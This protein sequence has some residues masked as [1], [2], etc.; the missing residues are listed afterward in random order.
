MSF[1][2]SGGWVPIW[3]LAAIAALY[4]NSKRL[5]DAD[6]LFTQC[7]QPANAASERWPSG[8][9]VKIQP[10]FHHPQPAGQIPRR[11]LPSMVNK[12]QSGGLYII[13]Y[14]VSSST[15]TSKVIWWPIIFDHAFVESSNFELIIGGRLG[16]RQSV[17]GGSTA[18]WSIHRRN[19]SQQPVYSQHHN[20]TTYVPI[21][22]TRRY[23][24]VSFT[25]YTDG[26][27]VSSCAKPKQPWY[28]HTGLFLSLITVTIP[29]STGYAPFLL[30]CFGT[31]SHPSFRGLQH[32]VD[33]R[34]GG[35]SPAGLLTQWDCPHDELSGVTSAFN[36][37][38]QEFAYMVFSHEGVTWFAG[39][40]AKLI[41]AAQ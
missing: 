41:N 31:G 12:F 4:R 27:L 13:F 18:P 15:A 21:N 17:R 9:R 40:G 32:L 25:Y 33:W 5:C 1:G 3:Q 26:S 29:A 2:Y 36:C 28:P 39:P 8:L 23:W 24:H 37:H 19:R 10:A 11:K 30:K 35:I 7:Y 38:G 20:P 22:P 34:L 16:I 14:S 6:I